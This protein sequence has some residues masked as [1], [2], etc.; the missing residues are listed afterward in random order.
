MSATTRLIQRPLARSAPLARRHAATPRRSILHRARAAHAGPAGPERAPPALG[1]ARP[2]T[3]PAK[4]AA[5]ARRARPLVLVIDDDELVRLVLQTVLEEEGYE[6]AVAT[7]GQQ[8]LAA[9]AARAPDLVITDIVMPEMNGLD[10]IREARAQGA[11]TPI[12][13]ISG[14]ARIDNQ[15]VLERALVLGACAALAKPLDPDEM[16]ALVRAALP[17]PGPDPAGPSMAR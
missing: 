9:L 17:A 6:V 16:I 2:A 11:A 4:D 14:G 8:G 15:D 3:D 12:I 7:D 5:K 13:A 10:L 1:S